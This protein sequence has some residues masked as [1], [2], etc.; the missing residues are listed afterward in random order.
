MSVPKNYDLRKARKGQGL[1]PPNPTRW[2]HEH[3]AL[4][5]RHALA[6]PLESRLEHDN[7]FKLLTDVYVLSH[8]DLRAGPKIENHFAGSRAK[9][10]SGMCI[11]C[12]DGIT[13][14]VYNSEHPATRVRATLM[15]EFFHL[16]LEHPPTNLRIYSD[17]DGER[18]YDAEKESEA[19]GSGAAALVPYK[20]LRAM[21]EDGKSVGL[22]ADHFFVSEQLVDFR[23]RV[24]KL[25][26]LRGRF[27]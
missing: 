21:L 18:D 9:K 3:N 19:Y 16:W 27:G 15:E 7:A 11:P 14:V 5:L 20:P 2:E 8:K 22:I 25:G 26:R 12:P 10:W 4:D 23:I 24:S 6:L 1:L 13:L 17:G